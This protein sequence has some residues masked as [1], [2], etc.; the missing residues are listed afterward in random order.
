MPN[1]YNSMPALIAHRGASAFAPENTAAAIILAAELGA[2]W[3]EVDVTISADGVDR[4][5]VV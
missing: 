5:S 4:K 2:T 1:I 3:C